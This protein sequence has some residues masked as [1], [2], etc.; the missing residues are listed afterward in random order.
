MP[1]M[2][3]LHPIGEKNAAIKFRPLAH[4]RRKKER[5]REREKERKEI[6]TA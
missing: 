4:C 3:H 2:G 1:V 5:E 6:K